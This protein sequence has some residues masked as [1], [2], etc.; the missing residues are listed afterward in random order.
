[1]M[2]DALLLLRFKCGSKDALCRIYQKYKNTLLKLALALA[3]R[4]Y[5][6]MDREKP[7]SES[8]VH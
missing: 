6:L 8:S 1:M 4:T 2:E 5:D 7:Q 3:A